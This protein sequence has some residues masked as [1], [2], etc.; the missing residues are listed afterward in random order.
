M[1]ICFEE[2]E[3]ATIEAKGMKII[4]FK[5]ICYRKEK[6]IRDDWNTMKDFV[7][8]IIEAWNT[9]K[10][11]FLSAMD[12]VKMFFESIKEACHCSVSL[13]YKFVKVLNKWTGIEK[14]KIWKMTRH[15]WLARSCC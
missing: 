14:R 4:E 3:R 15:T 1:I 10:D 12:D 7:E 9:F 5:K 6:R 8:K 2:K 13:R 11:N